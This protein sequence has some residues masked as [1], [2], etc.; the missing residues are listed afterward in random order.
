MVIGTD[1]N[2]MCLIYVSHL[3]TLAV[4]LLGLI[5]ITHFKLMDRSR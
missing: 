1:T 3:E 2:M 5:A 4:N